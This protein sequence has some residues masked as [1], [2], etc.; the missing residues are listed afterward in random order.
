[1]ILKPFITEQYP[2]VSISEEMATVRMLLKPGLFSVVINNENQPVGIITYNDYLI[3][4]KGLVKDCNLDKPCLDANDSVI[5]ALNLMTS[6]GSYVLPVYS[7]QEFIGAVTQSELIK[8]IIG[9]YQEY[10]NMTNRILSGARVSVVSILGL[11]STLDA[12]ISDRERKDT[13]MLAN[14]ACRETITILNKSH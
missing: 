4:P 9:T 10:K 12:D 7:G 6:C 14:K 3:H 1:M 2:T 8:T 5:D 13:L 11:I